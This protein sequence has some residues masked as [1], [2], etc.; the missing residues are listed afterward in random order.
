MSRP[1]ISYG[2]PATNA[3]SEAFM[4]W[5]YGSPEPQPSASVAEAKQQQAFEVR[6]GIT[7]VKPAVGRGRP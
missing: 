7:V 5:M 2:G 4:K 3:Q 6:G 1:I